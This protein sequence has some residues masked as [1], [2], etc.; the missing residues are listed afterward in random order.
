MVSTRVAMGGRG[1]YGRGS[2][3]DRDSHLARA[4][5]GL[6]TRRGAAAGGTPRPAASG[7][8]RR[9]RRSGLLGSATRHRR[10]P[11]AAT[12]SR[13]APALAG[14]LSR[15]LRAPPSKLQARVPAPRLLTLD[16]RLYFTQL[17]GGRTSSPDWQRRGQ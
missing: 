7:S 9:A 15:H 17:R 13:P 2:P 3:G 1:V 10:G 8:R 11:P 6:R 14:T 4:G 5:A 16:A 12:F